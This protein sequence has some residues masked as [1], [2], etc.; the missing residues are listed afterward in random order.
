MKD[1]TEKVIE[2]EKDLDSKEIDIIE[3]ISMKEKKEKKKAGVEAVI[4]KKKRLDIE[5]ILYQF[6][7][8]DLNKSIL[9]LI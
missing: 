5:N 2:T 8:Q 3:V 6:Q 7:G 9:N 4:E 1:T